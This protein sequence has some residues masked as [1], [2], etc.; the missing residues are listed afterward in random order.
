MRTH[1]CEGLK[2]CAICDK[3]FTHSYGLNSHMR[4]HQRANQ[5]MCFL[6][7]TTNIETKEDLLGHLEREHGTGGWECSHCNREFKFLN[8]LHRH[9]LAVHRGVKGFVCAAETCTYKTA[10]L[11]KIRIH[12]QDS[13]SVKTPL[14]PN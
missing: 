2:A 12:V 9:V 14:C 3:V 1:T 11:T 6:C 8:L 7:K 10:F 13:H 5:F 4:I